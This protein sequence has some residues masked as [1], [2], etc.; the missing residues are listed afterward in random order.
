L[1]G[2]GPEPVAALVL[3]GQIGLPLLGVDGQLVRLPP[4]ARVDQPERRCSGQVPRGPSLHLLERASDVVAPEIG[5]REAERAEHSRGQGNEDAL[6]PQ[7]L[8]QRAG[9]QRPGAAEGDKRQPARIDPA[10]Y[11][12]HT[13]RPSHLGLDDPNDSGGGL[14]G[15]SGSVRARAVRHPVSETGVGTFV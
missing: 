10:L 4:V 8:G 14:G 7:L 1:L 2:V 6:Y 15:P 11:A 5:R 9:V 3:F 12:D 13:E